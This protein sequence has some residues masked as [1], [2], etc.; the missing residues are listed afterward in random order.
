[1]VEKAITMGGRL[2]N[3]S[4]RIESKAPTYA[5]V[6]RVCQLWAVAGDKSWRRIAASHV[7]MFWLEACAWA[8]AHPGERLLVDSFRGAGGAARRSGQGRLAVFPEHYLDKVFDQIKELVRCNHGGKHT[9]GIDRFTI[10]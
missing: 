1:M 8:S 10:S 5:Q 6:A 4:R 3:P 7:R 9:D 2:P